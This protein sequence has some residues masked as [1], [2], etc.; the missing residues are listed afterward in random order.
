MGIMDPSEEAIGSL[1]RIHDNTADKI[2]SDLQRPVHL[3]KVDIDRNGSDDFVISQFGNQTGRLSWL[4]AGPKQTLTEYVIKNTP[5]AI[6]TEIQDF[7]NDGKLDIMSLFG[8]G[9]EG[10]SIFYQKKSGT[11][12]EKK[13]LRFPP[14]YGSSS[15]QLVDFNS[16]GEL[17]I[18]YSNGD[19]ADYSYSLK[20]YHGIRIYLNRG[21][22]EFEETFFYPMFGTTKSI[23]HDYDQDG[24]FDIM[25][26]GF[27]PDFMA[28]RP[29]GFVY[30][31]NQGNLEFKPYTFPEA[32][33]GRW[34]VADAGDIDGDGDIDVVLG[35]LLFKIDTAP[36]ELLERW[37]KHRYH[38][39]LLKNTS[40]NYSP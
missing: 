9:D 15:F 1:Y 19:N 28:S 21:N 13:I 14:V 36:P 25:A 11:F 34:L 22:Y 10:I 39:I 4:K 23:A 12:S 33:N 6:Q 29:E 32:E 26:I 7:N 37:S 35:S 40:I 8:Q 27:F 24:D 18:L 5:G 31:E 30:L 38:M 2:Y 3:S 20:A 17:D 16:D